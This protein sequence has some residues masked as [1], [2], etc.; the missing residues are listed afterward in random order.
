MSLF[1]R[2]LV[3]REASL[4]ALRALADRSGVSAGSVSV[5]QDSAR[6]HS[7]VWACQRQR[8]NLLST[9]PIDVHRVVGGVQVEVAKPP[10]LVTPGTDGQGIE[11]WLWATQ[12]DLDRFGNTFGL[13][14]ARDGN[15]LPSRVELLPAGEVAVRA[16]GEHVTEYRCGRDVW[17]EANGRIGDVW[18]ERAY[19][20]AGSPVGL[21]PVQMAAYALGQYLSAQDFALNWFGSGGVP[22]VALKPTAVDLT[23]EQAEVAKRRWMAATSRRGPAVLPRGWEI[24]MIDV[25]SAS[26]AYLNEKQASVADVCRYMDWP[27]DLVDGA[28]SGSSVTYAS[29]TQRN[30]QALVMHLGPAV[31]RRERALSRLTAGPRFVKFNTDAI[32]R[33]DPETVSRKLGLEVKDRLT[34][35]S[36]ARRLMNREPFTPEQIAE[37]EA[38][39]GPPRQEQT[40]GGGKA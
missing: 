9:L 12:Y 26:M 35:P 10:V 32:L 25:P 36:E 22:A 13:I 23:D 14:T 34:A 37:F 27:A 1:R 24:E 19:A 15:G 33:M 7:A 21:N 38:L 5:T 40:T 29:I 6:R 20:P 4:E 28:V 31:T 16:T 17:S 30:L 2:G 11:A 39:F 18:H 8:A 3:R